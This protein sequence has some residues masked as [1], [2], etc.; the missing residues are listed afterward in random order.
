MNEQHAGNIVY[1]DQ[2]NQYPYYY[3][4]GDARRCGGCGRCSSCFDGFNGTT[5]TFEY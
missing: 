4:E 5:V 1:W 2:Q 3:I